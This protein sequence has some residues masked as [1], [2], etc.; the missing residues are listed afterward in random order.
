MHHDVV[1]AGGAFE[2]DELYSAHHE[3][4]LTRHW[5]VVVVVHHRE[6]RKVRELIPAVAGPMRSALD[7]YPRSADDI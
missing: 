5:H 1:F 4:V 2:L 6:R 7:E 3:A